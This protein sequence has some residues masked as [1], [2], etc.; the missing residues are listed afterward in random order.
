MASD[1]AIFV[2]YFYWRK[3][4]YHVPPNPE[5]FKSVSLPYT[6]SIYIEEPRTKMFGCVLG[7]RK[8]NKKKTKREQGRKNKVRI[9]TLYRGMLIFFFIERH[10]K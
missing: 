1:Y 9:L 7:G 3:F 5:I 2:K 6:S 10:K 8:D 4:S